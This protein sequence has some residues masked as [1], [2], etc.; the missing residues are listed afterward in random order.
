VHIRTF[1]KNSREIW[2]ETKCSLVSEYT[3]KF[4]DNYAFVGERYC[5]IEDIM[6]ELE[7]SRTG[8]LLRPLLQQV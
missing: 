1:S 7:V 6:K 4:V 2:C 5:I 8:I 3:K